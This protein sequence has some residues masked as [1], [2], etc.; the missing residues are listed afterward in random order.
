MRYSGTIIDASGSNA[1]ERQLVD[2]C[3]SWSR[4]VLIKSDANDLSD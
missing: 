1:R 3:R 2:F 4:S